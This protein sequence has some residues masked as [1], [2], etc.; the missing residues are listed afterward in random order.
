MELNTELSGQPEDVFTSG[1]LTT[2]AIKTINPPLDEETVTLGR[3]SAV[4]TGTAGNP[5]WPVAV[6]LTYSYQGTVIATA[7][8]GTYFNPIPPTQ[9]TLT[10]PNIYCPYSNWNVTTGYS[11]TDFTVEGVG[12]GVSGPVSSGSHPMLAEHNDTEDGEE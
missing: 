9:V 2:I 6:T 4:G 1:S 8:L 5:P 10:N 11:V 7:N 12:Q 3:I